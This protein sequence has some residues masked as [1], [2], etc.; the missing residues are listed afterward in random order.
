MPEIIPSPESKYGGLKYW[1]TET[2]TI[3]MVGTTL[4]RYFPSARMLQVVETYAGRNGY[5]RFSS[6][7]AI[8]LDDLSVS[9][10]AVE[11]LRSILDTMTDTS[12]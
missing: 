12:E 9:T 5:R 7:S 3:A 8:N 10:D 6:I 4:L 1:K 11:L 2:P